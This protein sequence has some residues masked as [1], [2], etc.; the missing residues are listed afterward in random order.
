[1]ELF[2]AII[3]GIAHGI[4]EF[5][6]VSSSGHLILFRDLFSLDVTTVAAYDFMLHCATLL[7]LILYFRADIWA[8]FQ[9]VLRKLGRLPVRK[10][11]LTLAHALLAGT[12]PAVLLGFILEPFFDKNLQ[13]AAVVS[14]VL[15]TTSIFFMYVEWKYYMRPNHESIT[16]RKAILIGC[17]QVAALLPGFSRSGA[18][19][20]GGMLLGM[21][22]FE[23]ARFSFLLAIPIGLGVVGK[24]LIDL[25]KL[26]GTIDWTPILIGSLVAG[27][28][29]LIVIHIFLSYVKKNTLWPFIWYGV[30]LSAMV[31]YVAFIA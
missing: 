11:D 27:T 13:S 28:T 26:G 3:I 29:A 7:V 1:M 12:I 17:F 16:V 15:F 2:E 18:T 31:S 20:A 10:R 23:A 9:A 6:P 21:S 22:R 19:I 25:L 14:V 4:S 30:V 8:L 24:K 5:L